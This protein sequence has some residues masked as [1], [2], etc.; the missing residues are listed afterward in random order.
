MCVMHICSIGRPIEVFHNP[1]WTRAQPLCQPLCNR[2]SRF[3]THTPLLI[4]MLCV[5]PRWG[6]T[7][8]VDKLIMFLSQEIEAKQSI[9]STGLIL[10]RRSKKHAYHRLPHFLSNYNKFKFV[11]TF[12]FLLFLCHTMLEDIS[13]EWGTCNILLLENEK[14]NSK[15]ELY[16]DPV[17]SALYW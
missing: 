14:G 6:D 16:I 11:Y 3:R 15:N 5:P 1:F 7:I 13:I 12:D 2:V 17:K 10:P 4:N 9:V 8:I